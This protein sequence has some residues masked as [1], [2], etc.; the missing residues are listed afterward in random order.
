MNVVC[1][2]I[3]VVPPVLTA[4]FYLIVSTECS[5]NT[6]ETFMASSGTVISYLYYQI[7]NGFYFLFY[8]LYIKPLF[9]HKSVSP[10]NSVQ[11]SSNIQAHSTNSSLNTFKPPFD[12]V[13]FQKNSSFLFWLF[14]VFIP[15]WGYI[16]CILNARIQLNNKDLHFPLHLFHLLILAVQ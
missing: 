15:K 7:Y 16:F 4:H 6:N 3:F 2:T 5:C 10:W 11:L 14:I 12:A 9:L 8:F 1:T 13:S